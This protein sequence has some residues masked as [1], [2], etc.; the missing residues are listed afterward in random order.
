M[1]STDLKIASINIWGLSNE[2]KRRKLYLWLEEKKFD[3]V[4]LQETHCTNDDILKFNEGWKGT[5]VHSVTEN[6]KSK[7]VAIAF[8][9]SFNFSV[10]SKHVDKEGRRIMMQVS[11]EDEDI[12]LVNLYAPNEPRSRKIFFTKCQKWIKIYNKT[13]QNIVLGGDIMGRQKGIYYT[14]IYI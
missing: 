7:G 13:G 14:H 11:H 8:A 2:L 10:V 1:S 3:I 9:S 6:R 4:F 5:I 12:T